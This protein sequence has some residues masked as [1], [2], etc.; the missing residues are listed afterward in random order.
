[1]QL[2]TN[3][4]T[5]ARLMGLGVLRPDRVVTNDELS[6]R[7]DTSDEWIRTRVGISTRRFA[8]PDQGVV[9]MAE[10][11]G[12]RAIADAGLAPSDVDAVVVATCTLPAQIPNAAARVAHRVG[13]TTAGA[14]DVNAGCAGFVY[15][16][17]AAT[18][19]VT[20]GSARHVLVVGAEKLTDWIDPTDRTTAIIFGDGAGAVVVGAS[21]RPA[22]GPVAWG[23]AGELAGAITVG[24]K[25]FVVQDGQAVFH[26]ATTK[27]APVA[28]RAVEAAGLDLADLD[29]VVPHQ[30]NLRVV[31]ALV[32]D[33]REDGARPDLVVARDIVGS[34][35]TSSASIP[36]A[37]DT[38]RAGGEL[39]SG[40]T[41]LLVGFGA[42]LCYAAQVVVW[43]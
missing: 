14:F 16:L 29:A 2:R 41:T 8:A 34:G 38:L 28:R 5:H 11:A 18:A 19:L 31:E 15:A 22:V 35:N 33:L 4:P 21:D 30:A 32:R 10:V 1:M 36:L 6:E 3:T 42:G 23:A 39:R 25:G 43:P 13:A 37:L 7:M 9:D 27:I 40:M 24:E 12:A 20:A 26:W 17:G